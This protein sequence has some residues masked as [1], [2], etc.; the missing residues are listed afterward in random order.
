MK[1]DK[2]NLSRDELGL[3]LSVCEQ[4][5]EEEIARLRKRI[6]ATEEVTEPGAIE[7]CSEP[8]CTAVYIVERVM[9]QS[10]L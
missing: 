1:R 10:V 2:S 9:R 3:L 6:A 5:A 4:R 8:G 7:H